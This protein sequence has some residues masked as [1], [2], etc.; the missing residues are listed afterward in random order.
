MY[1]Q[2]T[3]LGIYMYGGP[4]NNKSWYIFVHRVCFVAIWYILWPSGI[5][6]VSLIIFSVLFYHVKSGNPADVDTYVHQ[7]E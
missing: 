5:L 6:N 3:I 2:I 7:L 1:T 4:W